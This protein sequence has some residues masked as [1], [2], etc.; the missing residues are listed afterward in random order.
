MPRIIR[1][2]QPRPAL[3]RPA[4]LPSDPAGL[5]AASLAPDAANVAYTMAQA[6]TVPT[7][8]A[9]A[10]S[11]PPLEI[12]ATI[13]PSRSDLMMGGGS[14]A[15]LFRACP[16]PTA[17][18]TVRA[19]LTAGVTHFDTAPHYGLGVSEERLG[20]AISPLGDD[21]APPDMQSIEANAAIEKLRQQGKIKLW[22]KTGRIIC[23]GGTPGAVLQVGGRDASGVTLYDLLK[24]TSMER[25]Q[26]LDYTAGGAGRSLTASECR[27]GGHRVDGLRVHD[28]DTDELVDK[29][30]KPD[31][32]LAGL[33]ALREAGR[34]SQ[35]SLGMNMVVAPQI[36]RLLREA[37]EGTFDNM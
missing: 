13:Q 10:A 23:A 6:L 19:A 35:V 21:L 3:L 5:P 34:I 1:A 36:L 7:P 29:C 12:D 9:L 11:L 25:D 26:L 2:L 22:T 28:A 30:L 17:V 20:T 18:A 31:G 16:E 15:G 27:F 24:N 8:S 37:P 4:G 33:R 14:I 32:M